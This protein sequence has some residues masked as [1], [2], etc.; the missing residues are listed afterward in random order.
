MRKIKYWLVVLLIVA[1][2]MLSFGCYVVQG[3]KMKNVK[4]TYKLVHYTYTPSYEKREGYTPTTIDYIADRGYEVYLVVTGT[5]MGYYVHKDNDTP[6][7]S[8]QV[9]LSYEYNQDDSS[10]IDYVSYA[11]ATQ[12][13]SS[14]TC[15]FGVTKNRLNYS[16]PAFDYTQLFTH[17]KM[18]S[19]DVDKDW[20]KVDKATD[21]SYV[22]KQLGEIKEYG[23]EEYAMRGIYEL[24]NYQSTQTDAA[25]DTAVENPYQYYFIA[26]ETATGATSATVY[27]ALKT[28]LTPVQ[29]TVTLTQAEGDW[30]K[31]T[32][33]G[34]EWTI[35]PTWGNY[36]YNEANGIR[37]E[38]NRIYGEVSQTYIQ[39]LIQN[40]LPITE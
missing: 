36:Y 24:T 4:G 38:I 7:Y 12:T 17:K 13:T 28:D 14:S 23:Y 29:K 8:T 32:I 39:E 25:T 37:Q 3:Q 6:A 19:E 31:M 34:I 11:D 9:S 33:D 16:L 15:K 27:Y 21:L 5:N 40:K 10:K 35:D 26:L 18:R 2:S 22:K 20:E 30:A 1:F